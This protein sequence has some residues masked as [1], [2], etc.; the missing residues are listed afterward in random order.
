M[1]VLT[2]HGILGMIIEAIHNHTG[3][4][5]EISPTET[6]GTDLDVHPSDILEAINP[7]LEAWCCMLSTADAK[8]VMGV[9]GITVQD[10]VAFVVSAIERKG[11]K[12]A[13]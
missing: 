1:I 10:L 9:D 5:R 2:S 7:Q 3:L 8:D 11:I 4:I 6:F 12:V 13:Q